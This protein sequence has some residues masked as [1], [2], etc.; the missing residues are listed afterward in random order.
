M[1]V[2]GK[3]AEREE[4]GRRKVPPPGQ[5]ARGRDPS[6]GGAADQVAL[7]PFFG[8]PYFWTALRYVYAMLRHRLLNR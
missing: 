5:A 6:E 2:A 1:R 4:A 8:L 3:G 7:A